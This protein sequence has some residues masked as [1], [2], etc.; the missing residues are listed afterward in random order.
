MQ[1]D[2]LHFILLAQRGEDI[3]KSLDCEICFMLTDVGTIIL[4]V[5]YENCYQFKNNFAVICIAVYGLSM[6]W[7]RTRAYLRPSK[8]KAVLKSVLKSPKVSIAPEV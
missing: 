5:R 8:A 2:A 6:T 4:S 7:D 3:L 1:R